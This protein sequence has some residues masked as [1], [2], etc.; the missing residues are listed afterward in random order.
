MTDDLV[1]RLV[2]LE[3]WQ[4]VLLF[5]AGAVVPKLSWTVLKFLCNCAAGVLRSAVQDYAVEFVKSWRFGRAINES[6]ETD[7]PWQISYKCHVND[8]VKARSHFQ[9]RE[10]RDVVKELHEIVVQPYLHN[11]PVKPSL[12]QRVEA[13]EAKL[14]GEVKE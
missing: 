11:G 4:L 9:S 12:I 7:L 8:S 2:V 6:K 5:V 3:L 14:N 13:L 10:V 1:S